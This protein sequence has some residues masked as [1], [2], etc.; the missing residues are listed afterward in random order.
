MAAGATDSVFAKNK[1][2]KS[3][4]KNKK[5]RSTRNS[6]PSS[7]AEMSDSLQ[8]ES[9]T[10]VSQC[11]NCQTLI[12]EKRMFRVEGQSTQEGLGVWGGKG[13]NVLCIVQ[14]KCLP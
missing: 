5:L 8:L 6:K 11:T 10:R 13:V 12:M 4:N 3:K 9:L 2:K 14:R 1:N 7:Y